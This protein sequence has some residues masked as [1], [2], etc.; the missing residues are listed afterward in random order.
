M[1]QLLL[2]R[3]A[4]SDWDHA[5]LSDHDRPLNDR[6]LRDCPRMARALAERGVV[7]GVVLSSTAV[8]ARTT[9]EAIT[10]GLG[11]DP[12]IIRLVP[13]LYLAS[14]KVILKQIQGLDESKDTAFLFGHNPGMHET[15]N[16][17]AAEGGV[18]DFPTLAVARF[19]LDLDHWGQIEWESGRLMELIIPRDLPA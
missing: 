4:K 16:R 14:D 5:G 15:V 10:S 1:K 19:E 9:A 11:L 17:L 2:I 8:R 13:D 6:G 3:H 18:G 12:A 7:P